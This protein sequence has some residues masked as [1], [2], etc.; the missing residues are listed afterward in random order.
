[1]IE[2]ADYWSR[3]TQEMVKYSASLSQA[4]RGSGGGEK[5]ERERERQQL[6]ERDMK[7]KPCCEIL[8]RTVCPRGPK[9][10]GGIINVARAAQRLSLRS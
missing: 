10:G 7:K 2:S 4:L 8:I 1:M 5:R 9:I 3:Q 6:K